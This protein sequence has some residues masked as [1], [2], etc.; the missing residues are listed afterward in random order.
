MIF[1]APGYEYNDIGAIIEEYIVQK[2]I[3]TI[4]NFCRH[5]IKSVFC[6]T[7]IILQYCNN[8]PNV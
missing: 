6:T 7:P 3:T 2:G 5:G 4:K 8:E 1:Y